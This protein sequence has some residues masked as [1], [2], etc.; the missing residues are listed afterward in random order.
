MSRGTETEY[1]A[2]SPGG[3][4]PHDEAPDLGDRVRGCVA[5]VHVLIRGDLS[6]VRSFENFSR[7]TSCGTGE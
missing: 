7:T 4:A 2:R 5:T 1:K 6:H 3:S